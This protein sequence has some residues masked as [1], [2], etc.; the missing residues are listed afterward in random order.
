MYVLFHSAGITK[1]SVQSVTW[2]TSNHII[3]NDCNTME[4]TVQI[5]DVTHMH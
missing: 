5:P 3:A 1:E 4:G 2:N